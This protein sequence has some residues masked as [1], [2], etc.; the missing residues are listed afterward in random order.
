[1]SPARSYAPVPSNAGTSGSGACGAG[2][3]HQSGLLLPVEFG[4]SSSFSVVLN[5]EI[6]ARNPGD[7][8]IQRP[9]ELEL[10]SVGFAR[11][12]D[13]S[14]SDDHAP[15]E[16]V[17]GVA[18]D[19]DLHRQRVHVVISQSWQKAAV[20]RRQAFVSCSLRGMSHFEQ[21]RGFSRNSSITVFCWS[22]R[23]T[24]TCSVSR[25][26]RHGSSPGMSPAWRKPSSKSL[27]LPAKLSGSS[28]LTRWPTMRIRVRE[29][30]FASRDIAEPNAAAS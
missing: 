7:N 21:R 8:G 15:A 24:L 26:I 4:F 29:K 18:I 16:P 13:D 30:P 3:L 28:G 10:G 2:G 14:P 27:T 19:L 23:R 12:G 6:G 5:A 22:S 25:M 9:S 17:V 1:M 11:V 20:M